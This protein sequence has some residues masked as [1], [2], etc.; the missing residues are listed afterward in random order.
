MCCVF[1]FFVQGWCSL[2]IRRVAMDF[3]F[4][5][6]ERVTRACILKDR[7]L[8]CQEFGFLADST[9][10]EGCTF[11]LSQVTRQIDRFV[12]VG[13]RLAFNFEIFWVSPKQCSLPLTL[14]DFYI[15]NG[16][17]IVQVTH[18]DRLEMHSA[19]IEAL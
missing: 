1:L 3:T 11:F 6:W 10:W 17:C 2:R 8:K 13:K 9:S 19:G 7:E 5:A 15:P 4:L 18:F 14:N 16:I 12:L